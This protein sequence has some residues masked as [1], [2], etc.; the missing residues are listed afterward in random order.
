MQSSG[1]PVSSGTPQG[2]VLGSILFVIYIDN[3]PRAVSSSAKMFTDNTE[4][5]T[6]SDTEDETTAIQGDLDSLCDWS[7]NRQLSFHPQRCKLLK[8][9]QRLST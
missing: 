4:V 2:S 3:L 1:A 5:F 9:S 6:R 7:E 8:R